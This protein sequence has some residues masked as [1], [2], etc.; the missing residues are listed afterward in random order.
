M[1]FPALRDYQAKAVAETEQ[2]ALAGA[3]AAYGGWQFGG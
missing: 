1:T 3:L 2:L